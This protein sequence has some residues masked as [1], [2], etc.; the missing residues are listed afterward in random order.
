VIEARGS[1]RDRQVPHVIAARI[2]EEYARGPT[3]SEEKPRVDLAPGDVP[4][5][6]FLPE[7]D[8]PVPSRQRLQASRRASG[9]VRP[10]EFFA[11]FV[12]DLG[13]PEG[14]PLA[15]LVDD[16][17]L[18]DNES[19]EFLIYLSGRARLSP[20]LLLFVLDS[21]LPAYGVWDEALSGRNDVDWVRFP[22]SRPDPRDVARLR[23]QFRGL[24]APAQQLVRLVALL[25]G[26]TSQVLLGRI[27][28]M[29]PTQVA[30]SL[31]APVTANLLRIRGDRVNLG[32][33][34]WAPIFVDP[35][36][37]AE[38]RE[39]HLRIA[40]ALAAMHPE[41]S[42]E[43]LVEI[44]DHRFEHGKDVDA[45]RSLTAAATSLERDARFDEAE[46]ATERAIVCAASLPTDDR[47]GVE[48]S[49]RV[50]RTRLLL[51]T[52]RLEEAERE[53]REGLS[54]AS[55][56]RLSR[57][58]L[59]ELLQSIV[60]ALRIAGPRPVIMN[61]LAELADRFH[62]SEAYA[63]EVLTI[64]VLTEGDLQ[65]GRLDK[66]REEAGRVSRIAR[67]LPRGP[68]QA[69]ALLCVAEPL[70]EGSEP[71]RRIATR[72]IRSARALL[73]GHRRPDLQ[74]Y[75]DEV[76]ARRLVSRGE[77]A[78]AAVVHEQAASVAARTRILPYELIH[79]LS[80][81]SLLIEDRADP[82]LP[83]ALKRA[84][85]LGEMLRLSPPSPPFLEY[86]LLRGRAAVKA[87]RP[88]EAREYWGAVGSAYGATVPTQYRAEAWLRLADLELT[89]HLPEAARE[90]LRHLE[91]PEALR[92]LR[93]E[94]APWLA[95]LRNRVDR[96]EPV[97]PTLRGL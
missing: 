28:R 88:F 33:E 97:T 82:R 79:Q 12:E 15:I 64:L 87:D 26:S 25:G 54:M 83:T 86:L 5:W 57:E 84:Q 29:T 16:A 45:L 56:A 94:W 66:A 49:L 24:S 11:R 14:A 55:L 20:L 3:A 50:T 21:S 43:Q 72:C 7:N 70:I 22:W 96:S 74:L 23:G 41:P 58:R 89:Q 30:E 80:L 51:S 68:M 67:E 47:L 2:W 8:A 19:R 90:H 53:F 60:P 10:E 32:S 73:A 37:L 44:A 71:E 76:H 95:D 69:V 18:L 62:D 4:A 1:F 36:E 34:S 85:Q 63:A 27:S 77:R 35:I 78:A 6:A 9:N 31:H 92:G 17:S 13:S 59:E 52:G 65:R 75:A 46:E 93:L 81:A 61:D 40:H 48:A 38:R 42:T 91:T 39:L